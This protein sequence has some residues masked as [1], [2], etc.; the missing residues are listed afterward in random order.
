MAGLIPRKGSKTV[1]KLLQFRVNVQ[2]T[3]PEN[4]DEL[5]PEV[6]ALYEGDKKITASAF[7][8]TAPIG[9]TLT[10]E[11]LSNVL[12]AHLAEKEN[13]ILGIRETE[14]VEAQE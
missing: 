1:A 11:D 9:S 8:F 3:K 5:S 6:A 7:T 10:P 4:A 12:Y 13:E 2:L 14:E